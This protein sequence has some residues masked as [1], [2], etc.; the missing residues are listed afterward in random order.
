MSDDRV[1]RIERMLEQTARK[2]SGGGLHPLEILQRVQDAVER[3]VR[4][5]VAPN[6]IIIGLHRADYAR[7]Q[8]SFD[9]LRAEIGRLLDGVERDRG[10]RRIGDRRVRFAA[11]SAASEGLPAVAAR[12]ADTSNLAPGGAPAGA[13][14]RITRQRGARLLLSDGRRVAVTHTPFAIGRGPRNDLV[15]ASL[16]VSRQ[17][18]ILESSPV[19]LVL[20]DCG[21]R[22][23]LVVDGERRSDVVL[24]PG[25]GVRLGDFEMWLE[26]GE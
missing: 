25:V 17:H 24:T 13:T 9:R 2:V 16:A 15:L 12:F 3:G 20:R 6:D 21:S 11:D 8:D 23:G 1:S 18:A 14:K 10:L 26:E 4:D 19:G 5:G 7:F 22:N